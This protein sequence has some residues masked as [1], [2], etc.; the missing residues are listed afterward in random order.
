MSGRAVSFP[1]RAPR[2]A[3]GT[4]A[5]ALKAQLESAV[6]LARTQ[7][8]EALQRELLAIS[9]RRPDVAADAA[10]AHRVAGS[11]GVFDRPDIARAARRLEAAAG[12]CGSTQPGTEMPAAFVALRAAVASSCR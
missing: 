12:Q 4:E 6:A 10:W 2:V 5:T 8:L 3:D 11:A 1:A 7:W 9:A